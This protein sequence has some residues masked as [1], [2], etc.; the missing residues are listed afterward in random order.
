VKKTI[1]LIACCVLFSGA[2]AQKKSCTVQFGFKA[3]L[4]H[5]V[6]NGAET[7]GEK[8]GFTGTTGYG[9]FFSEIP[10]G[11]TTFLQNELLFT[12]TNDWHF[13]E[14]PLY[15]KQALNNK[16]S[17]LLGP[18]LDIVADKF[19][20]TDGNTSDL[21]GVSVETGT[22]FSF[23]KR[24]FVEGRYSIGLSKQF[25]DPFFD[26]NEGRRNNL[27]FGIGLRF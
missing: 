25:K 18:K 13:I 21:L 3:G 1:L 9:A 15:L 22:Q 7:S 26:I 6:I 16:W 2:F 5:C 20:K 24:I 17:V 14:I 27:R 23:S 4:N 11:S 8:T 12:W 10:I 19:D